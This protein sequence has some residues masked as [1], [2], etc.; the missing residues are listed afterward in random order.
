MRVTL[1]DFILHVDARNALEPASIELSRGFWDL[2]EVVKEDFA[3][4]SCVHSRVEKNSLLPLGELKTSICVDH[5]F[6]SLVD[7]LGDLLPVLSLF[8]FIDLLGPVCD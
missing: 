6:V 2:W 5:F 4:L 1:K 7:V 3:Y 8:H